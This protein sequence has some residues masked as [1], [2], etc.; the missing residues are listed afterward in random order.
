M[1]MISYGLENKVVLI[2]G[3]N[4]PQGIGATTAYAF[5]REKAKLVLVYKKIF[6]Q[7]DKSKIHKN[8]VDRYYAANAGNADILENKIKEID[9]ECIVLEGDISN[10]N[11]VKEIYSTAQKKCGKIDVLVNNAAVDDE[12]G[13]DTI[14]K[15][16]QKVIDETFAVNVR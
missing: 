14:E 1:E 15:V 7:F 3:V 16:T 4:N 8:G 5:A 9:V 6:R 12:N 13:F 11:A 2:T 10:E